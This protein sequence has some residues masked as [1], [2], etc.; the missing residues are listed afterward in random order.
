M[1]TGIVGI[2]IHQLPYQFSGLYEISIVFFLLNVVLFVSLLVASIIQYTVWPEMWGMLLR[3]PMQS[4]YLGTVPIGLSTIV[5]MIIYVGVPLSN[6]F[7]IFAQVLFWIDV[8]LSLVTCI[9]V[10]LFMYRL[11]STNV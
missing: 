3:H 10:T 2:L 11:S 1:G 6:G 8:V 5:V 9:G 7:L 4:L